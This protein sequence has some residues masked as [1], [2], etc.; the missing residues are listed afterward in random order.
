MADIEQKKK[1]G[2]RIAVLLI[3]LSVS[4]LIYVSIMYKIIKFGP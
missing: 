2:G 1:T 3:L 4:A